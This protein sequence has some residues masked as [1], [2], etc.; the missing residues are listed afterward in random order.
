MQERHT[1][2]RQYFEELAISSQKYFISYLQNFISIN[3]DTRVLEVGC[4]EGGNLFPFAQKSCTV[5]GIDPDTIKIESARAIFEEKNLK[6]TMIAASFFDVPALDKGFDLILVHD[7]IEH[8]TDKKAFF[9][10]LKL[11][12]N[13]NGL[14]FFGFPAWWMPFGGHQQICSHKIL[15]KLP[16]IHLLPQSI[17]R[18]LLRL[19]KESPSG[20]DELLDIKACKVS[21]ESFA[22]LAKEAN[23]EIL[24]RRLYFINPHYEIKF[25]LHPR[26]LSPIIAKIP[27]LRNFFCTSCFYILKNKPNRTV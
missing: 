13:P 4:G 17:Y 14:V 27:Y 1:N 10:H 12:L 5:V 2:H 23:Y 3:S 7:V 15:S 25:G 16:F 11:F 9:A 6:A 21:I 19:G 18:S 24:D 22:Q 8:I 20:I 26:I